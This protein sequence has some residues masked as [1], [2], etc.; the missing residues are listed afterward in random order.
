[1]HSVCAVK[2]HSK[3]IHSDHKFGSYV[4][5]CSKLVDTKRLALIPEGK[6]FTDIICTV[7]YFKISQIPQ[8][9]NQFNLVTKVLFL[10]F[11]GI[12]TRFMAFT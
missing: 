11:K 1:M 10:I 4:G 6:L 9:I 12:F 5:S 8:Q 7:T 2:G 3:F